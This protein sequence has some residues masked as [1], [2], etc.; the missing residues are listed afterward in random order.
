MAG[1]MTSISLIRLR[2]RSSRAHDLSSDSITPGPEPTLE[3]GVI[4][5][6]GFILIVLSAQCRTFV[7][8]RVH[9]AG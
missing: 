1:A 8:H 7:T 9:S 3:P 5:T 2:P 4:A 6:L